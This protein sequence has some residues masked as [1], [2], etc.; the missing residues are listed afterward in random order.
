MKSLEDQLKQ[1]IRKQKKCSKHLPP[2]EPEGPETSNPE[3]IYRTLEKETNLL[4]LELNHYKKE[5]EIKETQLER[6]RNKNKDV[7][8]EMEALKRQ[9]VGYCCRIL[10]L[11]RIIE[12]SRNANY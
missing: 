10:E 4:Q 2:S 1:I 3:D 6:Q 11:E 9:N 8:A 5:L 12:S 7:I